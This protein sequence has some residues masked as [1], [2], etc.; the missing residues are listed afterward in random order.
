MHDLTPHHRWQ[1]AY[2]A[3]EDERSPFYRQDKD[4]MH[5]THAVYNHYIHPDWD[6]FVRPPCI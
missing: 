6:A 4:R 2:I 5:Y 3:D 1:A